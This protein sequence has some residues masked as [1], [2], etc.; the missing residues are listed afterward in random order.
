MRIVFD[1]SALI[2]AIRSSSGAA[3]EIVRLLLLKEITL[4]LDY[5]L[6]CEY[7]DVALRLEH[8]AASRG[9]SEAAEAVIDALESVATPVFVAVMHRPLSQDENDDMVLDVAINGRADTVV[10]NNVKDFKQAARHFGI[11]VRTPRELLMEI[12]DG[13]FYNAT[14]S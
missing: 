10:T 13:G 1:T 7:R 12:R 8:I 5:K 2:S 14:E 3:A 11:K 9:T 6:V 4:L